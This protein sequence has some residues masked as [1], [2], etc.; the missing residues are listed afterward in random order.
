M[1]GIAFYSSYQHKSSLLAASSSG[2]IMTVRY[3]IF[4]SLMLAVGCDH[5]VTYVPIGWTRVAEHKWSFEN[6]DLHATMISQ[7]M[8]TSSRWLVPEPEISNST[9]A[10]IVFESATIHTQSGTHWGEFGQ[11]NK[12][13]RRTVRPGETKRV[14]MYFSFE[15]PVPNAVGARFTLEVIYRVGPEEKRIVSEFR[16]IQ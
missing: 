1:T 8:F 6:Q 15:T 4:A 12:L 5:G 7:T 14:P 16:R 11:E 2:A 3:F 10:N 9:Q 13:T